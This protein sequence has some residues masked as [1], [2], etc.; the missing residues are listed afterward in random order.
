M[1]LLQ[2]LGLKPPTRR[3]SVVA[4]GDPATAQQRGDEGSTVVAKP[5]PPVAGAVAQP[6]PGPGP[7]DASASAVGAKPGSSPEQVAYDKERAAVA[8]LRA[9]LGKHKQAAHVA[10]KTGQ[11]DAALAAAATHA[12][13]PDWPKAMAELASAKTACEDGKR[14]ADGFADFLVKRAEANLVLT[15]ALTSGWTGIAALPAKLTGADTKAAPATRNYAGAKT[16]C[17]SIITGLAPFFKKFYVDD[18]K[19]KI[20][21]LK[22]LAAAKF[23]ASEIAAIDALMSKQ[24]TGITAKQWRQVRLNAGLIANQM[25]MAEKI[26]KRRAEFDVERP[27]VDVA[28]KAVQVHGK[29]VATPLAAIQQR[30]T[31]ADGLAA[32]AGM[33]FEDAKD[34]VLAIIKS[35]EALDRLARDAAVYTQERGALGTEL[36]GLRGHASADKIKAELDVVRGLLDDAAKAAGD[37]GA[38][39]TQ[40]A[41]GN[42]AALHDIATARSRLAQA[43]ASLATARNLAEGL[44]GVAAMEDMVKG[45]VNA[46]ALRKGADALAKELA[47]ALKAP[48]ADL[49][50]T[51]FDAVQEALDEVKKKI[52]DKQ[53]EV[54]AQVLTGAGLQLTAGRRIQIEHSQFVE[55]HAAL[56][57]RLD[58]HNANKAQ[59]A[60]IKARIDSFAKALAD[61]DTA[62]KANDHAKAIA[63]L[64]AAETAAGAADAAL[65][66]RTAFDKDANTAQLDLNLPA[67]AAIKV[68]QGNELTKARA[69]AFVFDFDGA[70]KILKSIRNAIGAVEAEAMAKKA[71]PDPKLA[72]K[73]KKLAEAGATKELDA[74]IKTLPT[75][76]DKQVFIDL[77][78]ARFKGVTF[79]AEAD[80]NEQAS[81]K[82]MCELMKDIPDDVIG[83]PSLKK[84]NRRVTKT[85][86]SGAAQTFPYYAANQNEVVMNSRPKQWNKPDFQPGAAGR[87]PAREEKCKPANNNPEDL[88][89]FNML[90][91]LAHAIDDAKNYM[92]VKGKDA[93]HGGW[94]EIGGNVDPI[95]EAVIKETGFGKT[96]EERQYVLDR[97]LR[98][99]AVAPAT[100]KGDKARFETF[101]S[102]AQTDNVWDSQA[103]TDQA[104][105]GGRVYHEGYPNTWFSYLADARKRGITSYQ[106]RAP[107]E[108]FSELYA[109]WKVG[110]LK[111]GHPA[112]AWL[113][114]LKI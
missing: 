20:A 63:D 86:G 84:I 45:K 94:I 28:L 32:K 73:A 79:E 111:G 80:G 68:A 60:K 67:N 72:D 75:T 103:L 93:D 26:A 83:N 29:A 85:D 12:A 37:K 36:S 3:A 62:E 77:A 54:A 100:F 30:L 4:P 49:A 92:G 70:G 1:P 59:A 71:P 89:D 50:K 7:G 74:L 113:T 22:T 110:K 14:F 64:N 91:E 105:L 16:D 102:A 11:A 13:T 65:V 43:R 90:H 47:S 6:G 10:D 44:D 23:I 31:E 46:V 55:R 87:L 109:A 51:Q 88:F 9:D 40:L 2:T 34:S 56:K 39:G 38:P 98:N 76:L 42:D 27:K 108:W 15:A 97:I 61:A 95:V 8:K 66:A 35:C 107:G 58:A 52:D 41:L 106:F 17:D 78:Q 99:P 53:P 25:A 57:T 104:T 21:A 96:P 81:I 101:I 33:R 5:P 82:R 19:P 24:E 69:L 48:N 112:E 18:V 114:K